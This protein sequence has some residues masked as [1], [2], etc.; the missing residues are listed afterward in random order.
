[1][2]KNLDKSDIWIGI[3]AASEASG[4][5]QPS[6]RKACRDGSIPCRMMP[7]A[8]HGETYVLL[9]RLADFELWLSERARLIPGRHGKTARLFRLILDGYAVPAICQE[10]GMERGAVL[11]AWQ[12]E[13]KRNGKF[14][15][16]DP[17]TDRRVGWAGEAGPEAR[18]EKITV[19]DLSRSEKKSCAWESEA[20]GQTGVK[21]PSTAELVTAMRS[22]G[23][24][25]SSRSSSTP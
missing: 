19:E 20:N 17:A 7:S 16:R 8:G 9:F 14:P 5:G 21:I 25:A 18:P 11:R 1:M 10:L 3:R 2:L 22:S 23:L 15:R 13:C 6:I 24:S 4:V 12:R